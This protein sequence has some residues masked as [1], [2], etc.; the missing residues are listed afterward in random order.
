MIATLRA[1]EGGGP[2]MYTQSSRFYRRGAPAC[3]P[4]GPAT[5]RQSSNVGSGVAASGIPVG[6][7]PR[8]AKC[9]KGLRNECR[10]GYQPPAPVGNN[11]D[12]FGRIL[13]SPT[14]PTPIRRSLQRNGPPRAAAPTC[15]HKPPD[16]IV[17]A[18]PLGG[19][20]ALPPPNNFM[21]FSFIVKFRL[22]RCR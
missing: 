9:S 22:N 15:T 6:H 18:A 13:S 16:F 4:G 11:R 20:A 8:P 3:A 10:G 5:T 2:Y 12:V 14:F 21:V 17:G 1:A 7:N 19:P